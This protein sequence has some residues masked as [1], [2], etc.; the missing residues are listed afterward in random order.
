[1]V[2]GIIEELGQS[3]NLTHTKD[4]GFCS[5]E[6]INSEKYFKETGNQI[7]L[8]LSNFP[9]YCKLSSPETLYIN[10]NYYLQN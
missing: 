2:A 5:K 1:M 6:A 10:H 4:I 3:G 7:A 9:L 8:Y